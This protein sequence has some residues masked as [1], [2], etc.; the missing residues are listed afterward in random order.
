MEVTKDEIDFFVKATKEISTYDFTE[1]SEKSFGRRLEKIKSDLNL[2]IEQIVSK[3]SN[4]YDF[5]ESIIREI[6]VNTTEL[7]RD[8]PLWLTIRE[9]VLPRFA[10][11]QNIDIWHPGVSNGLEAYSMLIMLSEMGLLEKT[12]SIGT[13]LNPEMLEIAK[14]G[15]YRYKVVSDYL[16]NFDVVLNAGKEDKDADFIPY[17]KYFELDKIKGTIKMKSFL[18]AQVDFQRHDLVKERNIFGHDF[19]LIVCRNLLIYFTPALQNRI[20]D[21][22]NQILKPNGILIL[23]AH[24]SILGSAMQKYEKKGALYYKR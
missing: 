10:D 11:N 17:S 9:E 13:D 6:T 14:K 20:F 8:P 1:Y 22:F 24:E 2:S 4:N 7:F 12:K 15:K 18:Q 23:G 21:F 19:D 3:M 16:A 5:L